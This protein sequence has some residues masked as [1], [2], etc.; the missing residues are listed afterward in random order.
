M[1]AI[2]PKIH[3]H[4]HYFGVPD[5]SDRWHI[6]AEPPTEVAPAL[7][8][9]EIFTLPRWLQQKCLAGI[10]VNEATN[11]P[12]VRAAVSENTLAELGGFLGFIGV[13]GAGQLTFE[14]QVASGEMASGDGPCM[15]RQNSPSHAI[16]AR[17]AVNLGAEDGLFPVQPQPGGPDMRYTGQLR[18]HER[19]GLVCDPGFSVGL[20]SA[21]A[22]GTSVALYVW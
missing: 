10:A 14:L 20:L 16:A 12:E 22:R 9:I 1:V 2:L 18:L 4:R 19:E 8:H 5:L 15:T 17:V 7:P 13:V 6:D 21:G 3:A 11:L